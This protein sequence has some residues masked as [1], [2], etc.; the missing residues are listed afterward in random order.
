M[1]METTGC[2][3]MGG[4]HSDERY[5]PFLRLFQRPFRALGPNYGTVLGRHFH[6]RCFLSRSFYEGPV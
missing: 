4:G 5:V 2:G 3:W 6:R 1:M